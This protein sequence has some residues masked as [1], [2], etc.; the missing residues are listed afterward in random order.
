MAAA[1]PVPP[2]PWPISA[3]RRRP[4]SSSAS[5]WRGISGPTGLG[6]F[7][8]AYTVWILL[9]MLYRAMVTEPMVISGDMR[10]DD[11]DDI[12]RQGFAAVVTLGAMAACVVAALGT[13][14]LSSGSTRSESDCFRSLHGYLHWI[15]KIIGARSVSCRGSETVPEERPRVQRGAGDCLRGH[16]SGGPALGIRRHLR[17]G[18]PELSSP[19][20]TGSG[21]SA[22]ARHCVGEGRSCGPDGR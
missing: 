7:A 17:R 11:K 4:I 6:A 18:V 8:L 12:I 9:T 19:V 10:R 5:S 14:F 1:P 20:C 2:P 3:W 22:S 15:C 21:S 16:F 13:T